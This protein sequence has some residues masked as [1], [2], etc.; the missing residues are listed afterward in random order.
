[1][2]TWPPSTST[3]TLACRPTRCRCFW[4]G[5]IDKNSSG[6]GLV[7]GSSSWQRRAG[8][9]QPLRLQPARVAHAAHAL[10]PPFGNPSRTA[11]SWRSTCS[12]TWTCR[13]GPPACPTAWCRWRRCPGGRGWA[14]AACRACTLSGHCIAVRPCLPG[15]QSSC[16]CGPPSACRC[17]PLPPAC[18]HC[19][20]YE[21][22]IE[23][24]GG[25]DLQARC[26]PACLGGAVALAHAASSAWPSP[27]ASCQP[28]L[29]RLLPCAPAA[30]APAS[31]R[32]WA[33]GAPGTLGSTRR[34]ARGPARHAS[35][36]WTGGGA[37][38]SCLAFRPPHALVLRGLASGTSQ[39]Q[40]K[41]HS[42]RAAC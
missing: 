37:G 23:E 31:S 24:A 5:G 14:A 11:A 32:S 3:S 26:P 36:R 9:G 17:W 16:C 8:T 12:A 41:S 7:G 30:R 6:W 2:P 10:L 21:R 20:E 27:P 22:A 4:E 25:I 42:T 39:M 40:A 34:G 35:S 13:R 18:R 33:W 29:Q 1:M 15:G 28:W 19:E 38:A